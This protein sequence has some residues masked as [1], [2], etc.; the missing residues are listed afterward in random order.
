[1]NRVMSRLLYPGCLLLTT[2]GL[3]LVAV[4]LFWIPITGLHSTPPASSIAALLVSVFIPSSVVCFCMFILI[5][6]IYGRIH[7]TSHRIGRLIVFV[8]MVGVAVVV[9]LAIIHCFYMWI[10]AGL[11]PALGTP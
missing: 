9:T 10:R 1:M 11:A 4:C 7:I 6:I 2:F 5:W 8:A 3:T